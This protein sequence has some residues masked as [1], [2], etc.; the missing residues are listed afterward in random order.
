MEA[1]NCE[2]S[3]TTTFADQL[4]K[5]WEW[6]DIRKLIEREQHGAIRIVALVCRLLNF[7]EESNNERRDQSLVASRGADVKGVTPRD[8]LGGVELVTLC[9]V[10]GS[11]RSVGAEHSRGRRPDARLLTWVGRKNSGQ[12]CS[13]WVVLTGVASQ[14]VK[15]LDAMMPIG[16][17][18][19]VGYV[20]TPTSGGV[21]E[22]GEEGG[23]PF[24]PMV[25]GPGRDR[26]SV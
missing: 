20:G 15:R 22:G 23:C 12:K 16:P 17:L 11:E 7:G 4:W 3:L 8:E 9:C 10:Q 19:D 26:S 1:P 5:L 2:E 21:E 14:E 6:C 13:G 18:K 24:L 25:S